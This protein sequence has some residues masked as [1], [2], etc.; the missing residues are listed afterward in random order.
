[1][2]IITQAFGPEGSCQANLSAAED[3]QC[4]NVAPLDPP[5]RMSL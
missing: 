3:D 4:D 1:M 2:I 5:Y